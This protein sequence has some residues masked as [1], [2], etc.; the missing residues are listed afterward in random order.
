VELAFLRAHARFF[1]AAALFSL[2]INL[3]LL[4]PSLY[5]LQVF[6]RVLTTRS[7]ETLAMLSLITAAALLLMFVLDAVR[8]RLLAL[9][10]GL[11]ERSIGRRALQRVLDDAASL[12]AGQQIHALRDVGALRAFFSGAGLVA[13]F[14]APWMLVYIGLIALF[15]PALGLLA[16][17]SAGILVL[18]TWINERATREALEQAQQQMRDAGQ[19]VDAALRNAEAVRALGM[20]PAVG[21]RWESLSGA[22][23]ARQLGIQR[24][25]GL[26]GSATRFFRQ[27]VQVAMMAAA[28]WL[29]IQQ[30]ATPGVMIAAT[31]ILGRALAPVEALIAQW[32][33]LVEARVAWHRLGT[34]VGTPAAARFAALPQPSGAITLDGLS[35]VPPGSQRPVVRQVAVEIA[36]GEVLAI[37]GPSGSGKSTLARLMLGVIPPS[38]G[39]VRL[40]G[41]SLTQWDPD[42]LGRHV[43]YL[44]QDVALFSGSVAENIARLGDAHGEAVVEAA[45]QAQAHELIVHLAQ[46]YDTQVGEAGRWLSGGQR[47]R[48][49]LARALYGNPRIVVLDEPNAHLDHDGEAALMRAVADLRARGTTVVLI[50]QRTQILSI[51]DRIM[52]MRD[53]IAERIGVRQ[54]RPVDGHVEAAGAT[55]GL[56]TIHPSRAS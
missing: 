53:G 47:Q 42:R 50:T 13:L 43:G 6:D 10:G 5:M 51:A 3:A 8:G 40:D 9:L 44:P 25:A 23:Q 11:F 24:I 7:V 35:Y 52:V 56:A 16:L 12:P 29:V 45:R 14:D 21:R 46:G 38:A 54:E 17:A 48:V 37:I 32:K 28:A 36:A 2:V 4:A 49:G 18:L 41:A 26:I 27:S 19:F 20:A 22:L 39:Q 30:L 15:S 34:L 33:S 55:A 31:I 1:V